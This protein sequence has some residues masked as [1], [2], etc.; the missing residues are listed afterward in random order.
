MNYVSKAVFGVALITAVNGCTKDSNDNG[1]SGFSGGLCETLKIAGGTSCK[2]P[3][4]SVAIVAVNNGYCTGTFITT[5]HVLTAGHC[6]LRG[7]S[8]VEVGAPGGFVSGANNVAVHPNYNG[9]LDSPFDVAVV[10]LR[11]AAPVT[12]V[13]LLLSQDISSGDEVVVYGYGLDESNNDVV[14]RVKEGGVPVKATS[15]EVTTVSTGTIETISDGTGDTCQGDSG[16]AL[17]LPDRTG[18]P[19]IVGLVRSGPNV[20]V[21]D[22]GLPSDNSNVQNPVVV[23]FILKNAPAT[24]TR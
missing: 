6:F 16:G 5:R 17:L 12:P 19:G 23:D 10:T 22:S 2:T 1:D 20:C 4:R 21:R 14:E 13:P 18:E 15:L 9:A 7:A 11:N 3:P 24:Q 8:R